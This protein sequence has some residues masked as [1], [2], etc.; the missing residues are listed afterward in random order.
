MD[1]K[2]TLLLEA[3]NEGLKNA[4]KYLPSHYL[5]LNDL[6]VLMA[7]NKQNDK[8]F[9]VIDTEGN[10]PK[11]FSANWRN[12]QHVREETIE[13]LKKQNAFLV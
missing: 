12:A 8:V 10:T 9:N 2:A 7:E 11:N 6:I 4:E 1:V 13:H 5:Q 3:F